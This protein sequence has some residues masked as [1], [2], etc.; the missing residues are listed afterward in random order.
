MW[1]NVP[2]QPDN[3]DPYIDTQGQRHGVGERVPAAWILELGRCHGLDA[4]MLLTGAKSWCGSLPAIRPGIAP[5]P[6]GV[7]ADLVCGRREVATFAGVA[8]LP[9]PGHTGARRRPGGALR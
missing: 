9:P 3:G 4:S 6:A 1:P 7:T 2:C 8:K 5:A